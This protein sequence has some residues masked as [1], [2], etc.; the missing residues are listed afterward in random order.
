MT[1]PAR[2]DMSLRGMMPMLVLQTACA[3]FFAAD[4]V[5]DLVLYRRQG[6]AIPLS[7]HLWAETLAVLA[8]IVAIGLELRFLVRQM[9]R[10]AMLEHNLRMAGAQVDAIL[11]AHFE[12]WALTGAEQDVAMFVVKGMSTADIARLR[13]TG[14]ATVKSHLNAIYRKSG[15]QGRSDLLAMILEVLMG[16]QSGDAP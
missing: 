10:Q 16:R 1:S 6:V 2:D 5:S 15:A 12:R 13:G 9:R 8:L 4:V 7:L 14:E 3:V 11:V